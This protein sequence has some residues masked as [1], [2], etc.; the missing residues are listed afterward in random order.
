MEDSE[1]QLTNRDAVRGALTC[2]Y[3]RKETQLLLRGG[4]C[5]CLSA[6]EYLA[7]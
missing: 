2:H 6:G 1:L 7:L 4:F 5:L 3:V